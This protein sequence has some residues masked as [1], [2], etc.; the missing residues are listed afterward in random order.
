MLLLV[1]PILTHLHKTRIPVTGIPLPFALTRD[2]FAAL[3]PRWRLIQSCC[4]R[5]IGDLFGLDL[6]AHVAFVVEPVPE[7]PR[8]SEVV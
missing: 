6:I 3:R 4:T 1:T 2:P 8:S 5:I 7:V